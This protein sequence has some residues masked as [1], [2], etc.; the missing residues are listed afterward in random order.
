MAHAQEEREVAFVATR[1]WWESRPAPHCTPNPGGFLA[2]TIP[3]LPPLGC[4]FSDE[5][6]ASAAKLAAARAVLAAGR[7]LVWTDDDEVPESGPLRAELTAGGRA[8]LIRPDARRGLTP[9]DLDEI[10]AFARGDLLTAA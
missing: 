9:A 6:D 4:A 1:S 8:L 7:R 10:E 3:A 2:G 5:P